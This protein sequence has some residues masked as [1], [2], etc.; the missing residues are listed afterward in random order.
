VTTKKIT[1]KEGI[2]TVSSTMVGLPPKEKS[3]KIKIRPF[4]TDTATVSIKYGLTIPTVQYGGARV[5]VFIS[6]P[7][8]QEEIPAVYKQLQ[9]ICDKLITKEAD[10]ITGEEED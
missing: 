1:E 7:C 6:C 8:Y 3:K 2:V 5:D 9:Y 4:V 10:R